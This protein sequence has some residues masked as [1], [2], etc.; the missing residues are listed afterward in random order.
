MKKEEEKEKGEEKNG[1]K[2]GRESVDW[3]DMKENRK[4]LAK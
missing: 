4:K 2:K 1:K 3:L